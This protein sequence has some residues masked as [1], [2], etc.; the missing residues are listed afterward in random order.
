[1]SQP[2]TQLISVNGLRAWR[3][4]YGGRQRH[5]R[6]AAL[7]FVVRRLDL[8]PLLPPP[9][10]IGEAAR[11]T[12]S[13]RIRELEA[14]GVKVPEILD[15]SD[16]VLV[17]SDLGPTL[18]ASLGMASGNPQRTD[19]LVSAA[20]AAI[21]DVHRRG[22]YLSQ[23]WPRN[24]TVDADSIG[25]IDFEE[26]PGEI[27]SLEH[28]QARDWLLFSYGTMRYYR[29]RPKT[30]AMTLRH[31]LRHARQDTIAGMARVTRRLHPLER[32]LGRFGTSADELAQTLGVLRSAMRVMVGIALIAL[33]VDWIHDGEI[34]LIEELIELF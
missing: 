31:A 27:M 12:E 3:K 17:L 11:H 13:A 8:P 24:L 9:Y 14:L 21:A 18:S 28:A 7:R 29:G 33:G 22:A 16:N 6:L 4:V 32:W 1:M 30:L 15:E 23:P 19:G 2:T 25:F 20:A 34:S 5:L 10:R 26:D